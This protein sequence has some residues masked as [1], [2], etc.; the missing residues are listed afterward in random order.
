MIFSDMWVKHC[1]LFFHAEVIV[2][3]AKTEIVLIDDPVNQLAENLNSVMLYLKD[4][5]L[6]LGSF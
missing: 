3:S 2:T 5:S 6:Q 1:L 4:L